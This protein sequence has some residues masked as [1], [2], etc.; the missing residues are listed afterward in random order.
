MQKFFAALLGAQ[1]T[2]AVMLKELTSPQIVSASAKGELPQL[3]YGLGFGAGVF[4]GHRW[5]GH[6]G[7]AP[8]VNVETAAYPDDRATVIVMSNR[9]PPA[10]TPVSLPFR[11]NQCPGGAASLAAS[12]ET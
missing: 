12:L 9:A 1:L 2:S 10:A 5:F 11:R 3:D 6:N 4:A 8:G 7:G